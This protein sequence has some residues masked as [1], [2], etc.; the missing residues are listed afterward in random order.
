MRVIVLS[1]CSSVVLPLS[2]P[3]SSL[4]STTAGDYSSQ[5][6][7]LT[8]LDLP[9][10]NHNNGNSEPLFERSRPPT[11]VDRIINDMEMVDTEMDSYMAKKQEEDLELKELEEVVMAFNGKL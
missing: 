9:N 2:P 5:P 7:A 8:L 10:G 4:S 1:L 6:Q 11:A 3:L